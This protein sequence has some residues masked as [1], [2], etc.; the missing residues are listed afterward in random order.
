MRHQ[1][2][3]DASPSGQ[4]GQRNQRQPRALDRAEREHDD[5][6]LGHLNRAA[7]GF[8]GN[9]AAD[10]TAAV[11]DQAGDMAVRHHHQAFARVVA[12]GLE[13]RGAARTRSAA[14]RLENLL[15]GKKPARGGCCLHGKRRFELEQVLLG[16]GHAIEVQRQLGERD[17]IGDLR[18]CRCP[19]GAARAKRCAARR[20]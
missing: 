12:A 10:R 8:H 18:C 15:N 3:A 14:A 5:R 9:D 11:G 19:A 17:R 20:R 1:V 7:V 4:A 13:L 2:G 6:F 16:V